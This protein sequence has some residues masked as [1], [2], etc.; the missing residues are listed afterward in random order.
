MERKE[1]RERG[2]KDGEDDTIDLPF[3]SA[4]QQRTMDLEDEL[5]AGLG[6]FHAQFNSYAR[7][8]NFK[9]PLEHPIKRKAKTGKTSK[10]HHHYFLQEQEYVSFKKQMAK[11]QQRE[12]QLKV[13]IALG[14]FFIFWFVSSLLFLRIEID[15]ILLRLKVGAAV[16]HVTEGWS[17]FIA[18]YFCYIFFTTIGYGDYHPQTQIGRAFFVAWSIL[19][20]FFNI[21]YFR[22]LLMYVYVSLGIATMTLLL[23]V[24]TESWSYKYKSSMDDAKAIRTIRRATNKVSTLPSSLNNSRTPTQVGTKNESRQLLA[25]EGYTLEDNS[26]VESFGE[27]IVGAIKGFSSHASYFMVSTKSILFLSTLELIPN[28]VK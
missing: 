13:G 23:S 12:F 18:L 25:I 24:I 3:V 19:G 10:H 14:L 5:A 8:L 21:V 7:L 15:L 9:K 2:E 20:S 4:S 28:F 26:E 6:Y 16:F 11:E 17:Y 22:I 1:R 27:K